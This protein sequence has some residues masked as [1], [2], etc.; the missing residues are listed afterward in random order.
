[1]RWIVVY[2][3]GTEFS[4]ADGEPQ[5]APGSGVIAVVQED[6]RVGHYV[7]HRK[8]WF[9][10]DIAEFDGWYN[11]DLIGLHDYLA[12]P[13]FKILKMGGVMPTQAYFDLI[14]RLNADPG[15]PSKSARY[16]G[17]MPFR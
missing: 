7:H 16:P 13:G 1:M 11:V 8:D 3:D 2:R 6:P 17:E 12:T 15:F 10:F 14:E 5:D 4:N 9:V